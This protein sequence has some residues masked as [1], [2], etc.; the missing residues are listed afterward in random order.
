MIASAALLAAL[1]V[2]LLAAWLAGELTFLASYK[3][4]LFRRH[5]EVLGAGT[6][7]LFL[8]LFALF[9]GISR[10]IFLR[11]AGRKLTHVDRQLGTADTVHEDLRPHVNGR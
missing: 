5:V 11:D 2:F 3:A 4:T 1:V 10:W 9:Y 6:L 7:L 8:N